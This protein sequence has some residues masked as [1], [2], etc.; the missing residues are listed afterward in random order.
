MRI[1]RCFAIKFWSGIGGIMFFDPNEFRITGTFV[2]Y[3]FICT[4]E[5]WLLSRGITPDQQD[6]NIDIGRF[7]HENAYSREK[8]EVD[9]YGMKLDIIKKENDQ[10]II[11]E[12]KKSSK[13]MESARMQLLHYLNELEEQGIHAEGVLLVPEE[14]KRETVVLNEESRKKL[15]E[16]IKGITEVISVDVPPEPKRINY[17]KNC[18]YSELC[19]A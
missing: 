15:S 12:I 11:G 1:L 19:W 14:K 5:V 3:Y 18:A 13:Y 6:D 10:L 4:R 8:K 9:F 16:A 7:L 2:W 17:C